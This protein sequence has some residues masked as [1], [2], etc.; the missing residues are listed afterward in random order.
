MVG[1]GFRIV[2]FRWISQPL[3][4]P[5]SALIL[6]S[7]VGLLAFALLLNLRD[8]NERYG[9]YFLQ[10]IFSILAFSRFTSRFWRGV[11]RSKIMLEWLRVAKIT[12]LILIVAG[13]LIAV[14]AVV[15]HHRTGVSHFGI[16]IF[17]SCFLLS[18]LAY[19][20]WVMKRGTPLVD[21]RF[22]GSH[23]HADGRV[24]WPGFRLGLGMAW[25][26][27]RPV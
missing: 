2:G 1:L 14:V 10:A 19:L 15:A 7:F 5:L 24:S 16:K 26:G 18:L 6:I 20:S 17:L 9:I 13:A 4:E 12:M 22:R 8:E 27:L 25:D 11:K 23:G 21:G 3:K